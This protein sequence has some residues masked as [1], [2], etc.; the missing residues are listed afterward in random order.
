MKL[1]KCLGSNLVALL[2]LVPFIAA[3]DEPFQPGTLWFP[4]IFCGDHFNGIAPAC[5]A[6]CFLI[7]L[8]TSTHCVFDWG[9]TILPDCH[10]FDATFAQNLVNCIHAGPD[11]CSTNDDYKDSVIYFDNM[12]RSPVSVICIS[13]IAFL[14]S[15]PRV[16]S[17]G[18]SYS[19]SS[20]RVN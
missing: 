3:W 8:E 20:R 10:C 5:G 13:S 16:I 7:N 11:A 9:E 19:T 4:L 18:S 17:T 12:C 14:R 6:G 1:S 2:N 15:D